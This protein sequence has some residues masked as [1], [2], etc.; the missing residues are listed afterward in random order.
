[1]EGK[2]ANGS[3]IEKEPKPILIL[4]LSAGVG[5]NDLTFCEGVGGLYQTKG[6]KKQLKHKGTEE[7]GGAA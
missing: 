6:G 5:L 1:M 7:D 3:K 2:G 4:G